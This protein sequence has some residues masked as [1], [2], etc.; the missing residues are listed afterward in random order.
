MSRIHC[1][2]CKT[3]I[4]NNAWSKIK[5]QGKGWFFSKAGRAYCPEHNPPWVAE[6][7]KKK[8]KNK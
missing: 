4:E 3:A 8:R 6:W 5:A 2:E 1:Y 7:R